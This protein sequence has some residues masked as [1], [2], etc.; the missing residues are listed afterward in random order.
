MKKASLAATFGA[1][2]C[3][4]GCNA[5]LG[6]SDG[7]YIDGGGDADLLGDAATDGSVSDG[8]PSDAPVSDSP[9]TDGGK[10]ACSAIVMTDPR[11]CGACGHD[12]LFGGCSGGACQPFALVGD[13][14]APEQITLAGNT[15]YFASTTSGT[16]NRV[17]LDRTGKEQLLA[18]NFPPPNGTIGVDPS[19][20]YF[21]SI[22]DGGSNELRKCPLTGACVP[23]IITGFP[24][25]AVDV[26]AD[27]TNAYV[28]APPS[29]IFAVRESDQLVTSL[30]SSIVSVAQIVA[31]PP[32]LYWGDNA[33]KVSRIGIDGTDGGFSTSTL[34][35]PRYIQVRGNHVAWAG[36]LGATSKLGTCDVTNCALTKVTVAR[37]DDVTA[38]DVDAAHL[39]WV[40]RGG[41]LNNGAIHSCTLA[42]SCATVTTHAL[43]QAQ[44]QSIAV[45]PQAI[46]WLNNAG[47][48]VG[49]VMG[50]AK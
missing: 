47:G 46:Y 42:D 39:Y 20:V 33:N 43:G 27:G 38:V 37:A 44:P 30:T 50:V 17:D 16:I 29:T 19:G 15:I 40:A 24:G 18:A 25:P 22:P 23:Q 11:N 32:F 13:A 5:I 26:A 1:L 10:D 21:T 41:G 34:G 12:C 8:T 2:A 14:A 31:A 35:S 28:V 45:T 48:G 49:A 9:I 7:V 6:N 3:A 36:S 4:W